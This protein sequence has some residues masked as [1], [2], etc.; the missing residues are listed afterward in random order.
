M[1]PFNSLATTATPS[2]TFWVVSFF[3]VLIATW[4]RVKLPGTTNP[5]DASRYY[6]DQPE[7]SGV[8]PAINFGEY[9]SPADNPNTTLT[10]LIGMAE[11]W[12]TAA[13]G[14]TIGRRDRKSVV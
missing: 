11:A 5:V 2:L 6:L 3:G 8:M 1:R 4:Y 14:G 10:D 9:A 13:V 12:D 7:V